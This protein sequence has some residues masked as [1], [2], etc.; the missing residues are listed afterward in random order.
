MQRLDIQAKS[1]GTQNYGIDFE[2]PG[3]LHA[4]VKL[5]PHQGGANGHGL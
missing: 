1:T 2:L 3:M 4:T 5:N